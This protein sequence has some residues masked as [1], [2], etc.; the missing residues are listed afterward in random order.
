MDARRDSYRLTVGERA[1]SGRECRNRCGGLR[2]KPEAPAVTAGASSLV[3]P[4]PVGLPRG[5]LADRQWGGR[6]LTTGQARTSIRRFLIS[7]SL[8]GLSGW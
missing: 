7:S 8:V 5:F 4:L 3:A 1:G 6:C 2:D